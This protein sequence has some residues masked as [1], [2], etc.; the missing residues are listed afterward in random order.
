MRK[1][2]VTIALCALAIPVLWRYPVDRALATVPSQHLDVLKDNGWTIQYHYFRDSEARGA[3]DYR[4]KTI[5]L[6][7]CN[8]STVYHEMGHALFRIAGLNSCLEPL[9]NSEADKLLRDYGRTS[10]GEFAACAFEEYYTDREHLQTE[11]PY[12]YDLI[13]LVFFQSE[14]PIDIKYATFA[15]QVLLKGGVPGGSDYVPTTIQESAEAP[16]LQTQKRAA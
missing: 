10:I 13:N 11:L 4:T 12:T 14:H 3:T 7:A 1:V 5:H 9:Y 16:D 6:Y 15:R 2:L 8:E